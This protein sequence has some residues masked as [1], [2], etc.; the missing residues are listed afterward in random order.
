MPITMGPFDPIQLIFEVLN[1]LMKKGVLTSEE[2]DEILKKSMPNLND[3]EKEKVIS[4]L[5]GKDK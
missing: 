2:A 1:Q 3:E 5:K 4:S